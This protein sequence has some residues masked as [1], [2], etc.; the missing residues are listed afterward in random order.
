MGPTVGISGMSSAGD[1]YLSL[2]YQ[3]V[4]FIHSHNYFFNIY[5]VIYFTVSQVVSSS[6]VEFRQKAYR[7]FRSI[8]RFL[9]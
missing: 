4:Q 3:E 1:L 9:V 2:R 7:I 5:L 6:L 8:R